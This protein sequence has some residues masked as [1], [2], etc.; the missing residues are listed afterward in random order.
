MPISKI[1]EMIK[2]DKAMIFSFIKNTYSPKQQLSKVVQGI[3]PTCDV[4]SS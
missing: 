4:S 3:S 1:I 2:Q